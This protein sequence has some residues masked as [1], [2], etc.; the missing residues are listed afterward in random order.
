MGKSV[1][2]DLKV[3]TEVLKTFHIT[4]LPAYCPTRALILR[5]KYLREIFAKFEMTFIGRTKGVLEVKNQK[6]QVK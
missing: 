1:N 2:C 4:T 6:Y 3:P 5:V